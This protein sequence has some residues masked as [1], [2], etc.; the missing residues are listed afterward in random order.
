MASRPGSNS[1][2]ARTGVRP[3]AAAQ[4]TRTKRR[5]AR[6]GPAFLRGGPCAK[7]SGIPAKRPGRTPGH[8]LPGMELKRSRVCLGK[9]GGGRTW[10]RTKDPLI[11]S[12]NQRVLARPHG[13]KNGVN[14]RF[15]VRIVLDMF[16][17]IQ[18]KKLP[19]VAGAYGEQSWFDGRSDCR[20]E[21]S[22]HRTN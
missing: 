22:C 7:P 17:S 9:G 3:V 8:I 21:G 5:R 1:D 19:K 4:Y 20:L 13:S 15:I 10:A 11:K 12:C 16:A 2:P 18:Y 14:L 6:E